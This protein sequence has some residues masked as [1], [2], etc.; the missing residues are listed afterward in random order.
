MIGV[1][2]L[3]IVIIDLSLEGLTYTFVNKKIKV[4]GS[5]K[6]TDVV[7]CAIQY[8]DSDKANGILHM[9]FR[10]KTGCLVWVI[11]TAIAIAFVLIVVLLC[12]C[13]CKCCC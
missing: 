10:E 7:E 6:A 3:L 8:F 13:C 11:W 9:M 2:T 4:S 1:Y 5:V 12:C